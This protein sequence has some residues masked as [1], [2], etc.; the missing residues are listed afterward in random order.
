MPWGFV[1][2]AE[3]DEVVLTDSYQY[4]NDPRR[5]VKVRSELDAAIK[6]MEQLGAIIFDPADIP[7]SEE[8]IQQSMSNDIAVISNEFKEDMRKYLDTM[9]STEVTCLRDIIE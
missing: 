2:L 3:L 9:K 7:S 4:R 1:F 6:K 8:W 5:N